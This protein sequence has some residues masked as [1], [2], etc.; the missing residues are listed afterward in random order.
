MAVTYKRVDDN[1]VEIV[2][3]FRAY[4]FSVG[5][6]SAVGHGFPDIVIGKNSRNLLIEIK[7]GNKPPNERRLT[8]DEARFH[9]AWR[10][11]VRIVTCANDVL[12][13]SNNFR[14]YAR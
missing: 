9:D 12:D 14:S 1:Q 10:G 4:G 11:S 6:T 5:I 2:K 8:P 3:E 13:I 7:D